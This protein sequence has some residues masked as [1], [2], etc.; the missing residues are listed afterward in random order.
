M[1]DYTEHYHLHQWQ[2]QDKFLRTDFNED[3]AKI[4]TALGE[5]AA[6]AAALEAAVSKCGNCRIYTTQYIGTGTG[7]TVLTFPG[8]PMLVNVMGTNIWMVGIQGVDVGISKNAGVGGGWQD[9]VW[10]GNTVTFES[11]SSDMTAQCNNKGETYTVV[12]FMMADE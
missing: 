5:G 1:A 11:N 10:T 2:P 7:K 6:K 3:L 9:V 8:K 4:D 12:C